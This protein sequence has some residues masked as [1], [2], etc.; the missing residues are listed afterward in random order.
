MSSVFRGYAGARRAID[1][2]EAFWVSLECAIAGRA[3]AATSSVGQNVDGQAR[4]DVQRVGPW[5]SSD[6]PLKIDPHFPHVG[7]HG[8]ASVLWAGDGAGS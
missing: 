4:G 8:G 3:C 7:R 1:K 5:I 6:A 2:C